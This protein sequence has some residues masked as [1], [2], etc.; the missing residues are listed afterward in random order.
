M[1]QP[2]TTT[3]ISR[4]LSGMLQA[5]QGLS[6]SV[7]G[8]S[9][10]VQ[11]SSDF[12]KSALGILHSDLDRVLARRGSGGGWGSSLTAASLYPPA[13]AC[14]ETRWAG[15]GARKRRGTATCLP[16]SVVAP[17]DE[18]SLVVGQDELLARPWTSGSYRLCSSCSNHP[19]SCCPGERRRG[20]AQGH[21]SYTPSWTRSYHST[22]YSTPPACRRATYP[23]TRWTAF[24]LLL[25]HPNE[26]HS[27]DVTAPQRAV[28]ARPHRQSAAHHR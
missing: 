11:V 22:I 10:S 20:T 21:T 3:L 17:C 24:A 6:G 23:M 5:P 7:H 18:G 9:R 19:C 1:T 14:P 4:P 27:R 12:R 13:A 16:S 25:L 26:V 15:R 28:V 2:V 8:L